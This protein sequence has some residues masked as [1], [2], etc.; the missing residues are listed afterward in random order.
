M[1]GARRTLHVSSDR[2]RLNGVYYPSPSTSTATST[3]TSGDRDAA[4]HSLCK[5]QQQ[6]VEQRSIYSSSPPAPYRAGLERG[7]AN[8]G[9]NGPNLSMT[10]Q[11]LR[12]TPSQS[13]FSSTNLLRTGAQT[14]QT[15][16]GGPS[17]PVALA[18]L[19][20]NQLGKV[21]CIQSL[22]QRPPSAGTP[23][24]SEEPNDSVLTLAQSDHYVFSG[25]QRG[26]IHVWSRDTY[27]L[28]KTLRAH[29]AGCLSLALDRRRGVLFSGGGDG[30]V[31]A[32]DVS[33]FKCLYA[34]HAGVNSGA[35]LSL[36][37][38]QAFDSLVLGCQN[39]SIQVFSIAQK[40]STSRR[41]RM[42][43][44]AAR[45]SRFFDDAVESIA[46]CG[47]FM[48][49]AISDTASDDNNDSCDE[50]RSAEEE[51]YVIF[52][53]SIV[54]YA[55]SGYVYSLLLGHFPSAPS[56][57]DEE[58]LYSA[59]SDGEIKVWKLGGSVLEEIALLDRG[60]LADGD[61]GEDVCVHSLALDDE[62]LFAGLQS[63]EIEVW[64][65]ET[66]Q[67]IRLLSG[68]SA[69]VFTLLVHAHCVY[70]GSA[71]GTIRMWSS[72]L[73]GLGWIS[74]AST[75]ST[76]LCLDMS[77]DD[78]L[79]SGSGD[80]AIAFWDVTALD[81]AAEG[82]GVPL[83]T[84]SGPALGLRNLQDT[85]H[86]T[87]S[88]AVAP[89]PALYRH[90]RKGHR[91]MQA[92]DQWIRFKSVS[93]VPELQ[94]ECRRA[95][96]FLKDLMRQLGASD[97]RLISSTP[98]SNPLVYGR[99][100]ASL[101]SEH[102]KPLEEQPTVF[103]YG[104]YDVMPAGD[105]ELWRTNPFEL[106][107]RDGYLYGR[108]VSDDKGP[109]LATLFAVSELHEAGQLPITVVFCI[110]GEEEHGSLG[111]HETMVDHRSLF[112]QPRLILL[113]LSYW[114][115]E[116][117]PCLTYGM[118]GSIRANLRI[119]STRRADVHAGVWGGAVSEPLT[120]L[121]HILSRL[122]D[123]TGNVLI[124]GFHDSVRDVS[125]K[126][127]TAM[128]ELVSWITAKEARAPLVTRTVLSPSES[129][130]SPLHPLSP[131][132]STRTADSVPADPGAGLV[133][134]ERARADLYDQ[135][136]QRWRFPTLTVHHVDVSTVAA[137]N[138][139]TLI[140]AAA[141]ATLSVRVVPDQSLE[142]I[143]E[144]LRVHVKAV[145]DEIHRSRSST[146]HAMLDDLKLHL[147][148]R[149]NAQWWL[150]DPE[151]PVY[152]AAARAIREEWQQAGNEE[153]KHVPLLIREGGSIP[154]VPWLERF[155]APGA[156]AVNL[157]MGQSS[158][159]AHLDNERIALENLM[160]G[161]QIAWRLLKGIGDVLKV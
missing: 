151:T 115:G 145:F 88:A 90:R 131:S 8:G 144:K 121:S 113:S 34:V 68:H 134:D 63:G 61:T 119:E 152:Q 50:R 4:R 31:R 130:A 85:Y 156:V 48:P 108:G 52:D 46:V 139:A 141:Q 137:R 93:G 18:S 39:T 155:F 26:D 153:A 125:E 5:D 11:R 111:L 143:A 101:S 128:R 81:Q 62:L 149:P 42:R 60:S 15:T 55:H 158:D 138:N 57:L 73:Q 1:E 40:D 133:V 6:Q 107:G 10:Q 129:A 100:D 132:S 161:R 118:R 23:L 91:M 76:I 71:D 45:R 122:A 104:H 44:M 80:S 124:P 96:R 21:R 28:I 106:V 94:P 160:R 14:P 27:R 120:C 32:W 83:A 37:Y 67:R 92:L 116:T 95:A 112:G 33:T 159:N 126:E 65:L 69:N 56:S 58:V 84:N 66:M 43:E 3:A 36:A 72:D 86:H 75:E 140:P 35:I 41:E 109:V 64:D 89:Q 77:S 135:L 22:S 9:S 24:T 146:G 154:A 147:D 74:P 19:S 114:L 51:Q 53:S 49:T 97:A 142:D 87:D 99:F 82:S 105:E 98:S 12:R 25:S 38:S 20:L 30:K 127:K 150:A 148:V 136:M 110:E 13:S 54:D 70:S 2:P 47:S 102:G 78:I 157:P 17:P 103:V 16:I 59:G 7:H 29:T 117:T 123:S 79:I